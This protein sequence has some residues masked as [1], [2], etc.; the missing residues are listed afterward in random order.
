MINKKEQNSDYKRELDWLP[1]K[2]AVLGAARTGIAVAKFLYQKG[3]D[4]LISDIS[5]SEKLDFILASNSIAGIRHE[6][7]EHSEEILKCGL[8]IC[9]PGIKS[10]IPILI[11]AKKLGVPVWSE[12]EL[13]YRHSK[14]PI[15]AVTGSTGKTTT[16][17]MLGLILKAAGKV[18]VVAGNIGI[19]LINVSPS[20]A[21][22]GFIVAEVSSFQLENTD[23]F[24][25]RVAAILNLMKNHLDR[26]KH[27]EDY[28]AAK[29]SIVHNMSDTD[30]IVLN[31]NDSR[32]VEWA[33]KLKGITSITFFGKDINNSDCVWYT[34]S[35][36][37]YRIANKNGIIINTGSLKTKGVHNINNA[38]ASAAMAFSVGINKEAI[39]EGLSQFKGLPHRLEFVRKLNGIEYYNDSKATTA[40]SVECAVN[41]FNA[42]VHLIAGGK[43]KGC[44]FSNIRDSIKKNVKS[45]SLI[46]EASGRIY[47]EWKGIPNIKKVKSLETALENAKNSASEGD[48]VIL[49]PGCSSFDMFSNFEHR[50]IAFKDMVNNLT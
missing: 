7:E 4:V 35:H 8:I 22:D 19:P 21:E 36:I 47:R 28:Y 2:V 1:A 5:T 48:V 9:S 30:R 45:I 32:L 37:H 11:Q 17:S 29:K 34:D 50:G 27:E 41:S 46:G 25:P 43:D 12:I 24:K 13:G 49:S 3:V 18:N 39:S 23:L 38:C 42:N 31:G 40:E 6:A 33:E 44:D 16:V 26:Y 15:L 10:N 14:A 20:I